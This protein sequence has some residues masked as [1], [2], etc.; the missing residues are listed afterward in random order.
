[1][2]QWIEPYGEE[3]KNIGEELMAKKIL[4]E[5]KNLTG[6]KFGSKE[7]NEVIKLFEVKKLEGMKAEKDILE[8]ILP[9]LEHSLT[10]ISSREKMHKTGQE[11]FNKDILMVKK[12][13]TELT[14]QLEELK[15]DKSNS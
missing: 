1:M 4:G 5:L 14:Q 9:T 2:N 8:A 3:Q 10:F 7:A 15:K 6:G 11:L 12:R 13:I